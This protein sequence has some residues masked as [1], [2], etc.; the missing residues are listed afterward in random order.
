VTDR[1][2]YSKEQIRAFWDGRHQRINALTDVCWCCGYHSRFLEKAHITALILGGSDE[3]AN[4]HLLCTRCHQETELFD[5][6]Q[7]WRY[8]A[9]V[10]YDL[11]GQLMQKHDRYS[12]AGVKYD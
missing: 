8:L 7:Y 9:Y 12:N 2:N 11:I 1:K 3:L 6:D 4:I 5:A 10:K